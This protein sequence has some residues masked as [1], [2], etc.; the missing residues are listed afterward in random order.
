MTKGILVAIIIIL[1][2]QTN[3]QVDSLFSNHFQY[4][5]FT[6]RSQ[7]GFGKAR[8]VNTTGDQVPK[9]GNMLSPILKAEYTKNIN[10]S[11]GLTFGG[12]IGA[13]I[14]SHQIVF[15]STISRLFLDLGVAPEF[16]FP[17]KSH[18][19][20]FSQGMGFK[21]TSRLTSMHS[22][23]D[24]L[25]NWSNA[26]FYY[27]HIALPYF[28]SR[29]SYSIPIRNRDLLSLSLD[30]QYVTKDLFRGQFIISQD[31]QFSAG[32]IT[33][34]R[35]ILSFGLGYTFTMHKRNEQ[36]QKIK[37]D[38]GI[39][40]KL[41]KKELKK[42]RRFV[43]PK[44]TMVG[45]NSGFFM[46][47]SKVDDPGG[48]FGSY[49]SPSWNASIYFEQGWKKNFYFQG[50]VAISSYWS[51]MKF[52]KHGFG[53]TGSN[54]FLGYT[55]NAGMMKRINAKGNRN[56]INLSAGLNINMQFEPKGYGFSS[57]G[58]E[59]YDSSGILL[60][61]NYLDEV[62]RN[63]FPTAYFGVGKDFRM[64]K[65]LAFTIDY[66]FQ[67]GFMKV[68]SSDI[69]YYENDLVSKSAQMKIDGTTHSI[70]F[71]L[72]YRFLYEKYRD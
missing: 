35:S 71:G 21:I 43:H 32:N 56:L 1:F 42:Q 28:K 65:H 23:L 48:V 17:V 19:I 6:V 63:I 2:N 41:A 52:N 11:I 18:F 9:G 31:Q 53:A 54:A 62:H 15:R 39:D 64:T 44:T 8:I 22:G 60:S 49:K 4:D 69:S 33:A 13:D 34:N 61:Y 55:M 29:I 66:R 30:Y 51:W 58:G 40:N 14:Y 37:T 47:V 16:R 36:L 12:G 20:S 67:L 7:F 26:Q 5:H 50:G 59:L 24:E 70:N 3:A 45:V 46:N 72:K 27:E 57:G 68:Q 38:S 10:P 25:G